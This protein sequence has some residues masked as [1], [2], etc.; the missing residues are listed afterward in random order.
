M[1]HAKRAQLRR[2]SIQPLVVDELSRLGNDDAHQDRAQRQDVRGPRQQL[3]VVGLG[4][5]DLFGQGG[6][7]SG[8][9]GHGRGGG[10]ARGGAQEAR[11]RVAGRRRGGHEG[12][13]RKERAHGRGGDGQ[14]NG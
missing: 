5:V 2:P 13:A 4:G 12:V 3:P 6:Q 9:G 8:G 1:R 14:R 7:R 10:G 11:P